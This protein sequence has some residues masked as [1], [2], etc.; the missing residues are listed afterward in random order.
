[1]NPNDALAQALQILYPEQKQDLPGKPEEGLYPDIS[2][3]DYHHN[4]IYDAL[5]SGG[6]RSILRSPAH[7]IVSQNNNEPSDNLIFG[8]AAHAFMLTP[9]SGEIAVA[10]DCPRR[11]KEEKAIHAAFEAA[12]QGKYIISAAQMKT[13]EAM[14]EVLFASDTASMIFERGTPELSAFWRHERFKFLCKAR[15]DFL[16]DDVGIIADYK[17]TLDASP[18]QFGRHAANF[19]YHIQAAWYLEGLEQITGKKWEFVFVAQ[20]KVPPYA[21]GIY[22]IPEEALWAGKEAC[23]T[24]AAVYLKCLKE[25]NWPAYP[26]QI[27]TLMFPRWAL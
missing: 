14:R 20:E 23:I 27:Q 19:G 12:N 16:V 21:V 15:P 8:S 7:F 5:S 24:A 2:S 9:D 25:K 3:Q 11:S 6:I 13:L 1:M 26:D 4:P 17:T 22:Q 18:E 10:P